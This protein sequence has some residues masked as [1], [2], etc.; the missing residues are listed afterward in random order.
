[1]RRILVVATALPLLALGA[2]RGPEGVTAVAVT[3]NGF[4][5][6]TAAIRAGDTVTWTSLDRAGT[7]HQI[8]FDAGAAGS[9]V[10]QPGQSWSRTFPT[11]GTFAYHDGQHTSLKGTVVVA[12]APP[13]VSISSKLSSVAF[14][15]RTTL[16]GKVSSGKAKQIVQV[17]AR[18]CGKLALSR[19][20]T[21]KTGVGGSYRVVVRPR[22]TTAYGARWG[23]QS[24]PALQMPVRPL[25]RLRAA[26]GGIFSLR[27][28]AAVSFAGERAL[29]QRLDATEDNWTLAG[30]VKLTAGGV[31]ARGTVLSTGSGK[32]T[33][34][35]RVRALLPQP[36]AG[37]CYLQATSNEL[38][39]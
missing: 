15:G 5:P 11:K 19:I 3:P 23:K 8:V 29:L 20:A 24:S 10:L 38:S 18:P 25:L 26:G 21:A 14:G 28:Y 22:R 1:M 30:Q 17:Y 2:T 7:K 33:G 34:S 16:V 4:S 32:A 37:A 6:V 27:A 31:P 35:G 36:A 12:A 9:P 13:S 39:G